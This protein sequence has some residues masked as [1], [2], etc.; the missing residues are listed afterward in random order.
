MKTVSRS[1]LLL[2][3]SIAVLSSCN[4]DDD[5]GP[6]GSGGGT[7]PSGNMA[8]SVGENS[9]SSDDAW[10]RY[11]T[12]GEFTIRA[13]ASDGRKFFF[14]ISDFNGP[15]DYT[16]GGNSSNTASFEQVFSG[17]TTTFNTSAGA[18]GV[19]TISNFNESTQRIAG[20]FSFIATQT[21]NES[22]SITISEGSFDDV[23]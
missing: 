5:S 17:N 14:V 21:E 11:R 13:T 10:A 15:L 7:A 3:F 2:F 23:P 1:F 6:S 4:N 8:A 16:L 19:I 22:N 12:T 20:T 9:F 18:T